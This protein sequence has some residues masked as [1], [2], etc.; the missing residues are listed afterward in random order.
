M[1]VRVDVLKWLREDRG[2][3]SVEMV[4]LAIPLFIALIMLAS[5]VTAVSASKIEISHLA[6][7]LRPHSGMLAFSRSFKA[8]LSPLP[9]PGRLILMA[10]VRW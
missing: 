6:R 2:S 1:I 10:V 5:H 8:M 4:T 9:N 7:T 3:A